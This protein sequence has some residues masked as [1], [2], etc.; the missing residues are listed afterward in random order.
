MEIKADNIMSSPHTLATLILLLSFSIPCFS[1]NE[2]DSWL[3]QELSNYNDYQQAQDKEFMGML[4]QAWQ[5]QELMFSPKRDNNPKPVTIPVAP[6]PP[7][8]PASTV[9]TAKKPVELVRVKKQP[10]PRNKRPATLPDTKSKNKIQLSFYGTPITFFY[11]SKTL[12]KSALK[13]INKT[14]IANYWDIASRTNH[15]ELIKQLSHF[16]SKLELNDWGLL[17]LTE[18]LAK[19][20]HR[21]DKNAQ[22]LFIW[23][24]LNK[25]Q[26]KARIG[27]NESGIQ[28]MIA[29]NH[30]IY[31][32]PYYTFNN[33]KY[34]LV[35]VDDGDKP[36]SLFTYEGKHPGKHNKV[37]INLASLPKIYRK[38]AQRTVSFKFDGKKYNF[39]IPYN[40]NLSSYFDHYPTTE[41]SVY[42]HSKISA[43]TSNV[44]FKNLLTELRKMDERNAVNF[45]LAFVQNAF[46]YKTDDDQFGKEKYFFPD[47]LFIH[48]YSDCE[49]RS[50]L[51]SFLVRQLLDKKV[52][53]LSF[54]GHVATAVQLDQIGEG[55][56][57]KYNGD[58]Y[59]VA[60]PTYI[61][62]TI[63]MTM[64]QFKNATPKIIPLR[65]I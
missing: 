22:K 18:A 53:A 13:G 49:D 40:E 61:N 19:K 65:E 31:G 12:Q 35:L 10:V 44:L 54:P 37:D 36:G 32:T 60:D 42:F 33:D 30:T 48:K 27:Y 38:V 55:D 5:E 9:K 50:V 47:E 20:I 43:E 7:K 8:K 26:K 4:K 63:G 62:A 16:G 41:L 46:P 3:N 59:L 34:F 58:R 21:N 57:I 1:N 28:L 15:P 56:T 45:L 11:D 29:A 64:P 2:F 17:S 25:L 24:S 39:T 52:I 14:S 23:F 51:F 6:P